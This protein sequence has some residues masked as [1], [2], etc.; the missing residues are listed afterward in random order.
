MKA[1]LLSP[2]KD[3]MGAAITEYFHHQKAG[4]LRVFSSQFEEDEIPINPVS[5][6]HLTLPTIA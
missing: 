3:P 1:N 4:K 5:Y 2:D 6:T